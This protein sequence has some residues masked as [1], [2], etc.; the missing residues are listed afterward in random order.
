MCEFQAGCYSAS[1]ADSFGVHARGVS[2][3]ACQ[4]Q[5]TSEENSASMECRLGESEHL[6]QNSLANCV[7]CVCLL[8]CDL[9][10]SAFA[11]KGIGQEQAAHCKHKHGD[12]MVPSDPS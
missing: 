9:E 5:F 4:R 11:C 12:E 2:C 10:A 3:L 8:S 1:L 6:Q 7:L